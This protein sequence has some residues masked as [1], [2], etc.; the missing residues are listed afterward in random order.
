MF[1]DKE[2]QIWLRRYL[3][4]SQYN[5][6]PANALGELSNCLDLDP[7]NGF[8]YSVAYLCRLISSAVRKDEVDILNILDIFIHLPP[9]HCCTDRMNYS[10]IT[11][12]RV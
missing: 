7:R 8:P 3:N 12:Q 2:A 11:D 4:R 5:Q 6:T 10:A 9:G 1:H